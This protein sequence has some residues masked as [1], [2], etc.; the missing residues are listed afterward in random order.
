MIA[1]M[2]HSPE[3]KIETFSHFYHLGATEDLRNGM[4]EAL[5]VG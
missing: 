1:C 2:M 3:Y 5:I 4:T